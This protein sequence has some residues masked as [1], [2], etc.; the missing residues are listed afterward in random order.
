VLGVGGRQ[1][2]GEED[3]TVGVRDCGLSIE[4]Y[5]SLTAFDIQTAYRF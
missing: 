5:K 4:I 1:V 2:S 3:R